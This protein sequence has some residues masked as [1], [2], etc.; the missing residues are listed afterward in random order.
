MPDPAL[1]PRFLAAVQLIERVGAREFQIRYDD[2][3]GAGP[4]VWN[5]LARFRVVTAGPTVHDNHWEVGAGMTPL[6]AVLR[7]AD[8]LLDGGTCTHCHR[9]TGVMH[10]PDE[11][12]AGEFVCWY[13]YDPELQVYRRGCE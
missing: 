10:G 3:D 13:Q 12:P 6:G 7:L 4:T 9:P 5:A 2:N 1:D 11:M 8:D